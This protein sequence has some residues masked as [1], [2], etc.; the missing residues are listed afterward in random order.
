M[1]L[2]GLICFNV[3]ENRPEKLTK[4]T[5]LSLFNNK[6]STIEGLEVLYAP[7]LIVGQ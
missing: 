5:D 2:S 6:I 7:V 4:L 3:I 1:N